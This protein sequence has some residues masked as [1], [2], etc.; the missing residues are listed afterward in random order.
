VILMAAINVAT[1]AVVAHNT[2]VA[3]RH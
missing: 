2:Q 3:R 1:A